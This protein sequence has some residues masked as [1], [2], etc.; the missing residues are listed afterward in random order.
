MSDSIALNASSAQRPHFRVASFGLPNALQRVA[1]IVFA[2][3]R[4]NPFSYEVVEDSR[5]EACE[6]ALIDMTVRGNERLLRVLRKRQGSHVVLTVGRRGA[7][8][9]V[10]DDVLI[11]QFATQLLGVLNA[12]VAGQIARPAADLRLFAR[13]AVI[14]A[15]LLW[16]RAPRALVVDA[17]TAARL[18]L[19][20]RLTAAGW[21]VQGAASLGQA[22]AWLSNWPVEMV[23][24]DWALAD[25]EATRLW[26]QPGRAQ[27]TA[28][29]P[30]G[31]QSHS[32]QLHGEQPRGGRAPFWILL[33]RQPSWWQL[34]R[35]RWAGCAAV[36]DKPATP[37]TVLGVVDRLLRERLT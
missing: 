35:A 33:T 25:G 12:A 20:T 31:E 24:S 27:T 3:A 26:R 8:S 36:L 11:A 17:S 5:L 32:D 14:D 29:S 7:A 2:H 6:V 34:L 13:P 19:M 15:R 28:E 4:H 10:A 1:Q 9:R 18:Q 21:E 23:V 37:Q 30:S 16:G 22:M